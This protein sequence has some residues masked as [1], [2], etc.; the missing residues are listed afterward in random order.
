MMS[1]ENVAREK[2]N[3]DFP[4]VKIVSCGATVL[5]FFLFTGTRSLL[6]FCI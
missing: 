5:L 2:Y 3:R 6:L 1:T 4:A